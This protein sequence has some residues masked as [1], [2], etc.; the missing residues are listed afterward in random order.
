[1]IHIISW[2]ILCLLFNTLIIAQLIL[3]FLKI[4]AV[5]GSREKYI[6]TTWLIIV[7]AAIFLAALAC[8]VF[9]LREHDYIGAAMWTLFALYALYLLWRIFNED[10]NWFNN[11]WKKL[12]RG[13]K[14]L[15]ERLQSVGLKPAP[16]LG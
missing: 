3:T 15:R 16:A 4:K 8:V 5:A 14:N 10:D 2:V 13:L 7:T 9:G 11:Q 6:L 1:M 12:M